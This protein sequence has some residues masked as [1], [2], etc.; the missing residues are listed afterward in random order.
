MAIRPADL[1]GAIFQAT[2]VARV[3]GQAESAPQN[4]LLRA[5]RTFVEHLAEREETIEETQPGTWS[6][7]RRRS[8]AWVRAKRAR[9]LN[10]DQDQH[11]IDVI[12]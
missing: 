2:I 11:L 4:A 9:T 7:R 8:P 10:A 6:R 12:A 1:Q 5:A 3:E